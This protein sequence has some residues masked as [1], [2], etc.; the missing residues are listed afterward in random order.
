LYNGLQFAGVWP[1]YECADNT[2]ISTDLCKDTKICA[3]D[4]TTHVDI[5]TAS[6]PG[7]QLVSVVGSE[8]LYTQ[9]VAGF[10]N[11]IAGEQFDIAEKL[12]RDRGYT[13]GYGYGKSIHSKEPLCIVTND[14]DAEWS[15][16]VN[17]VLEG[18]LAAEDQ[19]IS[20][21]TANRIPLTMVFGEA[22][23]NMFR[24]AVKIVGNYGEVYDRNL[25]E[26]LPRPVPDL[27]NPG[28]SGLIYSFPF[29]SLAALGEGA[30]IG[31]T[32]EKILQRGFLRC[33]VSI[34]G[35]FAELNSATQTWHGRDSTEG[36]QW[37]TR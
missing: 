20:S 37:T 22:F 32:L 13:G 4:G 2:T 21:N 28:D 7:V 34:R 17:W 18:V 8:F 5:I 16:F 26:L 14:D 10:C 19:V 35:F 1:Y 27:I 11:V 30:V 36:D 15:D 24:N 25:Q 29:G 23:Q 6:I 33:G 31:G 12:V 3:L 9:F